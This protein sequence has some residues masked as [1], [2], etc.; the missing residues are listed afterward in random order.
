MSSKLSQQDETMKREEIRLAIVDDSKAITLALCALLTQLG[1]KNV[2]SYQSAQIAFNEIEKDKNCFDCVFTDLNMPEMD[3]MAFIR[4]LGEINYKGAIVIVS[5]M[6]PRVIAL[7]ADLAKL[8]KTRLIGNISK[9]IVLPHL[10]LV[11]HRLDSILDSKYKEADEL[12]EGELLDAIEQQQIEPFYQP[13]VSSI[14]NKVESIEVLARIVRERDLKPILPAQFLGVAARLGIENLIT[15][16]LIEK[17][18][19]HYNQLKEFFDY[20]FKFAVNLSPKQ[21]EDYECADQMH[22]ILCVNNLTP[23]NFIIEI[24]EEYALRQVSQ[25]ETLNRLRMAGYG[26]S[27]DDFGTGFTN[28]NQL[29]TLPFT[30]IKIDRSF[31]SRICNDKFSQVIVRSLMEVTKEQGV[32]IVAEG[33]EQF[34]E[35]EY[36]QQNPTGILL[37]GFLICKPKRFEELTSWYVK[38]QKCAEVQN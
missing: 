4:K 32:D 1:Y 6:E 2:K 22:T 34:D 3:G 7:A 26:I 12:T 17:A 18:A 28:L 23:A 11:L 25:L 14:T 16:Q 29:R 33:I 37:Q 36:L 35:L 19:V 30:E 27:L 24:T 20:D 13:K 9:P 31:I 21:M 8:N 15:L 5:E 38:W 10:E